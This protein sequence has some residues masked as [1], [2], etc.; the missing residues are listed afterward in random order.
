[1][2]HIACL[3]PWLKLICSYLMWPLALI[4][5]VDIDDCREVAKLVGIK[6]FTSE[7]LA[8][9]ELGKSTAAGLS[10]RL[11]STQT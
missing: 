4:M 5:G 8:Y 7:V 1:M 3:L 11:L 2:N 10:V 9:Q 6:I